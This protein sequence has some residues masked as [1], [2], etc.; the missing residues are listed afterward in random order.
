MIGRRRVTKEY[1]ALALSIQQM[2]QEQGWT[3]RQL[4]EQTDVTASYACQVERARIKP[5]TKY[6]DRLE[7]AFDLTH[8]RLMI[9]VGSIPMDMV[10]GF[11]SPEETSRDALSSVTEDERLELIGYLKLLRLQAMVRALVEGK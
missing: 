11:A 8:G 3:L 1:Q 6:L 9:R 5:S 2:R 7:Q 10:K 4:A